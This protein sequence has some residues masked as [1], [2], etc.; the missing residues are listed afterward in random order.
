MRLFGRKGLQQRFGMNSVIRLPGGGG[1]G[2]FA[3]GGPQILD[4]A[5]QHQREA[6]ELFGG[7]AAEISRDQLLFDGILM[8]GQLRELL[9]EGTREFLVDGF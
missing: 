9:F 5:A 1:D 8:F 6:Q 2:A 3:E 4:T 7:D